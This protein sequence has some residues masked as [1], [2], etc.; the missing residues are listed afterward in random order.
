M[1]I[2]FIH[3]DETLPFEGNDVKSIDSDTFFKL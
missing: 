2:F 3:L 1:V